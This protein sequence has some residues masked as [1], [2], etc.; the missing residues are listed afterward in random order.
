MAPIRSRAKMQ[1]GERFRGPHKKALAVSRNRMLRAAS[2]ANAPA[3]PPRLADSVQPSVAPESE[4]RARGY[5]VQFA[6]YQFA[7]V[8]V[9]PINDRVCNSPTNR[10]PLRILGWRGTPSLRAARRRAG[11]GRPPMTAIPNGLQGNVV[12]LLSADRIVPP[13]SGC[14][15]YMPAT[16]PEGSR[17]SWC[18]LASTP[19]CRQT[20]TPRFRGA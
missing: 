10:I 4:R 18:S 9:V 8:V 17:C 6:V 20:C 7:P 13:H 15:C 11:S 3:A 5:P 16:S 12:A 14:P 19:L 1:V 2:A